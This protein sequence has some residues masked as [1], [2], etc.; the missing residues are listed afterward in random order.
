[1]NPHTQ[2]RDGNRVEP[3]GCAQVANTRPSL[4]SVRFTRF[5]Q[6]EATITLPPGRYR[7]ETWELVLPQDAVLPYGITEPGFVPRRFH[8]GGD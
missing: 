8:V 3:A 2:N 6:R 7:R 1:M 5:R 4:R